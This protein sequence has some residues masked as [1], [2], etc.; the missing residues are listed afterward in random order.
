MK[1]QLEILY[2]QGSSREDGAEP[3]YELIV[4][5]MA[6]FEKLDYYCASLFGYSHK[7]FVPG[8][9]LFTEKTIKLFKTL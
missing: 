2:H 9:S 3:Y 1:N 5:V 4:F 6:S 7:V 8:T